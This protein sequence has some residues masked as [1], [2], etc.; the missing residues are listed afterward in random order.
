MGQAV[1][2]TDYDVGFCFG[3]SKN[4][5]QNRVNIIL[6]YQRI[7]KIDHWWK[8]RNH[9]STICDTNMNYNMISIVMAST[10]PT[11]WVKN[12]GIYGNKTTDWLS[13]TVSQIFEVGS[14]ENQRL[15]FFTILLDIN[16]FWE[17]NYN[18]H[19]DKVLIFVLWVNKG[20]GARKWRVNFLEE[21]GIWVN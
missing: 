1:T 15:T 9:H 16:Y 17:V 8:M 18:E 14:M 4:R 10:S 2:Q 13:S 19:K 7:E 6:N 3:I 11:Q 12:A 21:T 5:Y 20:W